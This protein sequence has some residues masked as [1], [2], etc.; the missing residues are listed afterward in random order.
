MTK[1]CGV[2]KEKGYVKGGGYVGQ[3]TQRPDGGVTFTVGSMVT[4]ATE[5]SRL[6][7]GDTLFKI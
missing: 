6:Q 2:I 5:I 7:I 1:Y 3:G 4:V